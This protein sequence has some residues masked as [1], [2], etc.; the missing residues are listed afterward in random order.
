MTWTLLIFSVLNRQLQFVAPLKTEK[1]GWED[2][3][4]EVLMEYYEKHRDIMDGHARSQQIRF[5]KKQRWNEI[6][7]KVSA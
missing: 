5:H 1:R 6:A 4:N 2:D 3:E 7:E